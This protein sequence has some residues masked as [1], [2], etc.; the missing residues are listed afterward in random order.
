MADTSYVEADYD[1]N[2]QHA[3]DNNDYCD[4]DENFTDTRQKNDPFQDVRNYSFYS[5]L[6]DNFSSITD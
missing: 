2:D 6:F 5:H 4:N 1:E 3:D